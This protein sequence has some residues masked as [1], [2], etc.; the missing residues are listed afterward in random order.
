MRHRVQQM[1]DQMTSNLHRG[2]RKISEVLGYVFYLFLI[3]VNASVNICSNSLKI[4]SPTLKF[5]R[6]NIYSPELNLSAVLD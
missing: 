5:E 3:K 2:C 4:E 1:P 6:K